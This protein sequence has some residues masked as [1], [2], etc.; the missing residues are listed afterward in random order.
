[1]YAIRTLT[2]VEL[3]T[4][5]IAAIIILMPDNTIGQL[6]KRKKPSP[7]RR[8]ALYFNLFMAHAL[9]VYPKWVIAIAIMTAIE[10]M[11]FLISIVVSIT[12]QVI[13]S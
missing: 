8:M 1:M 4:R 9:P 7:L 10:N 3:S 11:W 13:I 12:K 5:I 6:L 2:Y